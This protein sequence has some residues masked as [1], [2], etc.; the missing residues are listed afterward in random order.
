MKAYV[1]TASKLQ[2]KFGEIKKGYHTDY[3]KILYLPSQL[4]AS[5]GVIG[6]NSFG[7]H[8]HQSWQLNQKQI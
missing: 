3:N 6:N 2:K 8:K 4:S 1:Y 5:Y 7:T